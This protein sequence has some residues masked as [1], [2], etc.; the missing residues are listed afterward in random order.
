PST[1]KGPAF[2]RTIS[3]R[4]SSVSIPSGRPSISASTRAL[5]CRSAGRSW[6]PTVAR[7]RPPTGGRRIIDKEAVARWARASPVP[8][9]PPIPVRDDAP[10]SKRVHATC[11]ALRI[12]RSWQGVLLRGPSGAGKSDFALRLIEG[13]ARLVADDQTELVRKGS[14]VIASAPTRIAGLIE[15]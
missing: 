8:C 2:P 14:K 1:T 12:G 13:G 5:A 6:R 7:S 4:S 15:A 11:V 10:L 3:N 9:P